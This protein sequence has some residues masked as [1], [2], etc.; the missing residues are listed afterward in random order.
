MEIGPAIIEQV[1]SS[2]CFFAWKIYLF[3]MEN[4]YKYMLLLVLIVEYYAATIV[5]YIDV[6][7][8]AEML[9]SDSTTSF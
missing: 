7:I 5:S 9:T 1:Y 3:M 6:Y 8:N 2:V 4:I